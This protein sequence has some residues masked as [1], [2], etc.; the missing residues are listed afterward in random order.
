M[1][2]FGIPVSLIWIAFAA[3]WIFTSETLGHILA[4]IQGLSLILEIIVWIVFLPWV[5]SLWIW[6]SSWPLWLKIVAIFV[7]AMVT[8]SGSRVRK[9]ARRAKRGGSA[10]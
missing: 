7:I 3:L 10:R 1:T 9:A 2:F 5:G 4:W 8:M 6:H